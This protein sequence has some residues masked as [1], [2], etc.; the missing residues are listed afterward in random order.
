MPK[1]GH[2]AEPNLDRKEY[3]VTITL[4]RL[5]DG[6]IVDCVEDRAQKLQSV[7]TDLLIVS[8]QIIL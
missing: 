3:N 4:M 6:E 5:S 8:L 2:S 1:E 7:C